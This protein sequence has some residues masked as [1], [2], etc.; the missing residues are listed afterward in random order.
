M[1]VVTDMKR[2][3]FGEGVVMFL[4]FIGVFYFIGAIIGAYEAIISRQVIVHIVMFISLQEPNHHMVTH[5]IV[6]GVN[7][8]MGHQKAPIIVAKKAQQL[9]R[10]TVTRQKVHRQRKI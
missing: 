6:V 1:K 5:H 9:I 3:S 4:V 8:Y 10:H 7:H 2:V